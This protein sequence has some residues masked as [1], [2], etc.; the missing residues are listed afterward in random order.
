MIVDTQPRP[1]SCRAAGIAFYSATF[2]PLFRLL[3]IG[4]L[5][6]SGVVIPVPL[7]NEHSWRSTNRPSQVTGTP[8]KLMPRHEIG[9]WQRHPCTADAIRLCWRVSERTDLAK[10]P[11][12]TLITPWLICTG[13]G[14]LSRAEIASWLDYES[15]NPYRLSEAS[16]RSLFSSSRLL[17]G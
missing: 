11:C 5:N 4:F 2:G 9:S 3:R 12:R 16:Y 17:D 7:T 15:G 1:T 6:A 14:A 10:G 13:C 8:S